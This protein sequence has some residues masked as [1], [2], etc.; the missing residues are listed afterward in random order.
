MRYFKHVTTIF[1]LS[2]VSLSIDI[3]S[4]H[5]DVTLLFSLISH[6]VIYPIGGRTL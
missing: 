5:G 3:F 4:H 1:F 2:R 6:L